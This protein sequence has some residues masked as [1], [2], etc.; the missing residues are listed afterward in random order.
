MDNP[1][2]E[3]PPRVRLTVSNDEAVT[4]IDVDGEELHQALSAMNQRAYS[5]QAHRSLGL[6]EPTPSAEA[7]LVE[8][9]LV[10]FAAGELDEKGGF[11]GH[12][13]PSTKLPPMLEYVPPVD[14]VP[15]ECVIVRFDELE[16]GK[17]TPTVIYRWSK[18]K[19]LWE[20]VIPPFPRV[21]DRE[22]AHAAACAEMQEQGGGCA[23]NVQ[24]IPPSP[25]A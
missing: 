9:E 18:E 5:G 22:A 1:K 12:L 2:Y 17:P 8:A 20:P 10:M 15:G 7:V 23:I 24:S 11:M 21:T 16:P 3:G 19:D 25:E 6:C 14:N 13:G 4:V